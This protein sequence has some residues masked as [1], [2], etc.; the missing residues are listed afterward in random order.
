KRL[1]NC[2]SLLWIQLGEEN[3]WA[4]SI[5]EGEN[6]TVNCS[7]KTSITALQWY[8]QESGRGPAMLILIRSNER[9][10]RSGRLRV[11]LDTSTQRSSLSI[12]AAQ[13]ADTAVYF[14]ATD[15]QCAAGTCSPDTNPQSCFLNPDSGWNGV[16]SFHNKSL[17][18]MKENSFKFVILL[19][20]FPNQS[21]E[22]KI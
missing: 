13:A 19:L 20:Y 21:C 7:Y 15:A 11:T 6:V 5:Q 17:P 12:T 16:L 10:K 14:C 4:L 3:A 9:E 2:F 1:Q 22:E 18:A 8:R